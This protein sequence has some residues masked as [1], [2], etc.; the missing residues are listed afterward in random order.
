MK[1]VL[2]AP[3]ACALK[4][5]EELEKEK[6]L[7]REAEEKLEKEKAL[8]R[9]AE[10]KLEKEKALRREAEEKSEK[11]K[12]RL[13]SLL[14]SRELDISNSDEPSSQETHVN[15]CEK[16]CENNLSKIPDGILKW[17]GEYRGRVDGSPHSK[18]EILHAQREGLVFWTKT[19]AQGEGGSYKEGVWFA[20]GH[21]QE[22]HL[23]GEGEG[24]TCGPGW[25]T[26][27]EYFEET[28]ESYPEEVKK[29]ALEIMDKAV[30]LPNVSGQ[31]KKGGKYK[32]PGH[33]NQTTGNKHTGYISWEEGGKTYYVCCANKDSTEYGKVLCANGD[34]APKYSKLSKKKGQ[35]LGKILLNYFAPWL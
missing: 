8:R 14:P 21:D 33:W 30:W 7:R 13:G 26:P 18:E 34:K 5:K 10:E 11:E 31:T 19:V 29:K 6:A 22:E 15:V 35:M 1:E 23:D 20:K 9:E 27:E 16:D 3:L 32:V 17:E 28:G 4:F 24:Y 12:A 2:T 25:V